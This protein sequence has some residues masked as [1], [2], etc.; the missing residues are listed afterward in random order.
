[1]TE[2]SR[3]LG[4]SVS[5][6]VGNLSTIGLFMLGEVR[7]FLRK[8]WGASREEFMAAVDQVAKTMKQSGKMASGDIERA[9]D[10][11][12]KNWKILNKESSLEWETFFE[13]IKTR[14]KAMGDISR[15]TFDLTVDQAKRSLDRQWSATGRLGDEQLKGFRDHS[16]EMAKAFRGQWTVFWDTMEKTGKKVDRAMQA[17]WEELKKK[18]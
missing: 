15:E 6:L 2:E 7:S 1:M 5:E 13:E 3:K 9:A 8:S 11:I 10:E 14:L 18:E 4:E 12:K 16:E 17:A